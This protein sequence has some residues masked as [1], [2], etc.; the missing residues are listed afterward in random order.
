MTADH[1]RHYR[2]PSAPPPPAC[3]AYAGIATVLT[4]VFAALVV[5]PDAL[6]RRVARRPSDARA[7][8]AGGGWWHGAALRM[9]AGRCCT[10]FPRWCCY[11]AWP[12]RRWG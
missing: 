8:G 2:C 4:S 7:V 11:W 10:G 5:L 12:R 6:A 9:C 3:F 1:A